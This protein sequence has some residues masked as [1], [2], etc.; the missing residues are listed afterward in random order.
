[1]TLD[2]IDAAPVDDDGLLM[3]A[4][5]PAAQLCL[6]LV[7]LDDAL[8]I[9]GLDLADIVRLRVESTDVLMVSGLLDLVGERFAGRAPVPPLDLVEVEGL[10]PAGMLVALAA[11]VAP[12]SAPDHPTH[13]FTTRNDA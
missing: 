1:M 4:E 6:A 8:R 2:F 3:H 7:R 10:H 9:R 12:R 11:D 13:P 5:D